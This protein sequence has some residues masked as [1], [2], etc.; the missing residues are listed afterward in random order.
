MCFF[1][2]LLSDPPS[3]GTAR[4]CVLRCAVS[5]SSK[6]QLG[7]FATEDEVTWKVQG[8]ILTSAM[9]L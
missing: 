1:F 7:H 9:L 5:R 3:K 4:P 6:L 8:K 2:L